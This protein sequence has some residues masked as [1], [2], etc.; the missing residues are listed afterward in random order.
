LG[1]IIE[2]LSEILDDPQKPFFIVIDRLDE[3]WA[4]E[5]V[6]YNLLKGLID[7][8]KEFGKVHYAKIIICLRIDLI[9]Q[10]FRHV[11]SEAG[12]Q[13]DKYRSL[14]LPLRWNREHLIALLDRRIAALIRDRY[15]GYTPTHKDILPP[16]V[17]VGQR[18]DKQN[19]ID[20]ILARTWNRPRDII[21]F[22]NL[23]IGRCEGKPR[24][25]QEVILD[26]EADYSRNRLRAIYQEWYKDYFE[27]PEAVKAFVEKRP[28]RYL[29]NEITQTTINDWSLAV[30]CT[31]PQTKG[32]LW[33]LAAKFI[34]CELPEA[35]FRR[36]LASILYRTGI[37]GLKMTSTSPVRWA[38]NESYTIALAE[39]DDQVQVYVHPGL[40]RVLGIT[41]MDGEQ[42]E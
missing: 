31:Q 34:G 33:D 15:T 11:R 14:Y 12:F 1:G 28:S 38:D 8:V 41:H 2:L 36:N 26:V 42:N 27:L 7:A 21:E 23:S 13:E 4:D 9:E 30:A 29:L 39:L 40:W 22:L 6:R 18:K 19:T 5:A 37:V 24:L 35:D 17:R 20:F 16:S 32:R 3:Q 25:T 10:L